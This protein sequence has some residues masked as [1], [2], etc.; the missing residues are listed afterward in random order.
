MAV[1]VVV[2]VLCVFGTRGMSVLLLPGD[3]VVR[4]LIL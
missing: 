4:Q 2:T 1:A 3:A